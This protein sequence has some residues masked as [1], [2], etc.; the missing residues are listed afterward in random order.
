MKSRFGG[1]GESAKQQRFDFAS[2]AVSM[3]A[4]CVRT[5]Y[6]RELRSKRRQENEEQQK[7]VHVLTSEQFGRPANRKAVLLV[8]DERCA[9]QHGC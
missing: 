6:A 3:I 7:P 8:T 4:S 2:Q 1:L 5:E 9:A